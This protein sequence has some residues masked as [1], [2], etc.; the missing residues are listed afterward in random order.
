MHEKG[1]THTCE[2]PHGHPHEVMV[3][4]LTLAVAGSKPA[5]LLR[6]PEDMNRLIGSGQDK[7][8]LLDS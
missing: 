6:A 7:F 5:T 3:D 2:N 1:L 8:C 4:R